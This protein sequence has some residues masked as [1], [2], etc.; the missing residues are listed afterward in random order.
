MKIVIVVAVGVVALLSPAARAQPELSLKINEIDY[1]Q[2]G[3][4]TAEFIEI[5]NQGQ[6]PV[7]LADIA[8]VLVNGTGGS[9]YLTVP[10]SQG[11]F[12]LSPGAYLVLHGAGVI[13]P[14]GVISIGMSTM[15]QNGSPDGVAIVNTATRTLI[16]AFSY[17]GA[18][19]QAFLPG[20]PGP[21]NL[22]AGSPFMTPDPSDV[23]G[24]LARVPDGGDTQQDSDD[25]ALAGTPTPGYPNGGAAESI[26]CCGTSDFDGDGDFGT[27]AD[28]EAFFACLGGSCCA[29]CYHGGAD[30]NAD[31]DIG[32]DADIE[33]F[34]RVLGGGGC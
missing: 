33:A 10:L 17:E 3:T 2:P 14:P 13:V 8:V 31:G 20:F 19:T 32:T 34:F 7:P 4:D 21:V 30:F 5:K 28:I 11:G 27:D 6:C 12:Q 22:V 1:D 16:D 18:I 26:P 25:W 24:S 23:P 15:V 29:T 9:E